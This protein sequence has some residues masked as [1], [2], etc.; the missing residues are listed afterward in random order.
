MP[1]QDDIPVNFH[2]QHRHRDHCNGDQQHSHGCHCHH[3]E[4][5]GK[6]QRAAGW[7]HFGLSCFRLGPCDFVVICFDLLMISDDFGLDPRIHHSVGAISGNVLLCVIC[8]DYLL[9]PL[10]W[11]N[12]SSLYWHDAS[13][14]DMMPG[15]ARPPCV[16]CAM[17]EAWPGAMSKKRRASVVRHAWFKKV[18]RSLPMIL[19]SL[20]KIGAFRDICFSQREKVF[21]FAGLIC[22]MVSWSSPNIPKYS[23][24]LQHL[25][26]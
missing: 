1:P 18:G 5:H 25:A 7:G 15:P 2:H 12:P 14:S 10:P 6:H 22:E 21:G 17:P 24:L 9:K 8:H 16:A 13:C 23:F 19:G 4:H 11:A 20:W 3:D 26:Q